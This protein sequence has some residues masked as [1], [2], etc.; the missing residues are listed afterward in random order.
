[1]IGV[2][3]EICPQDPLHFM[4]NFR[5]PHTIDICKIPIIVAH[6]SFRANDNVC[7]TQ[8]RTT[9]NVLYVRFLTIFTGLPPVL[10]VKPSDNAVYI[11]DQRKYEFE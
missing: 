3:R 5:L 7:H 1:M 6:L 4:W 8:S 11:K 9:P 10:H 2:R